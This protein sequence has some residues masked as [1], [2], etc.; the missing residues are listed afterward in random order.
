MSKS[1]RSVYRIA[2]VVVVAIVCAI[3]IVDN[4][5]FERACRRIC[6][7]AI[8]LGGHP[9]SIGGWPIGREFVIRFD[10]PLTDNDLRH[11]AAADPGSRRISLLLYYSGE[12][13]DDR[14]A[15]M[16]EVVASHDI[17]ITVGL[18]ED[19]EKTKWDDASP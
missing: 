4:V 10:H 3:A 8:E 14:L 19:N 16:R 2:V 9:Y 7:V 6:T 5:Q 1:P 17:R 12:V 11:L 15:A 18:S 13:S